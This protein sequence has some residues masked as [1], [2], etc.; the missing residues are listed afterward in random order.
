[1]E[2]F[3]EGPFA[4]NGAGV[5]LL[6]SPPTADWMQSVAGSLRQSE[7]AFLVPAGAAW[8]LRWFTPRCEVPL[9]GHATLAALLALHHWGC[10]PPSRETVFH[11]RSGPLPV[12]I[13]PCDDRLGQ[14][15]L[16]H[17]QC[18]LETVPEALL[19]LIRPLLGCDVELFW[20]SSLGYAI[21]L[22][23]AEAPSPPWSPSPAG[24][25]PTSAAAW[26]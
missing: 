12:R 15:E 16:P 2:A 3:S 17:G 20:R 26:C 1:M 9:C 25:P 11:T 14:L 18:R 5:V 6:E 23:P 21:A 24:S 22:L 7:T 4:G 13:D 19:N 10:L 8:L